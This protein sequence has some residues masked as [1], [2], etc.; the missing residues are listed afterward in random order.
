MACVVSVGNQDPTSAGS[1][2][3][4]GSW[5]DIRRLGGEVTQWRHSPGHLVMP[6][7]GL[8]LREAARGARFDF[9]IKGVRLYWP[10]SPPLIYRG[11]VAE[12]SEDWTACGLWD[13]V[14]GRVP[15]RC[16]AAHH[17]GPSG[18][19]TGSDALHLDRVDQT[20]IKFGSVCIRMVRRS[21]SSRGHRKFRIPKY[22]IR[23]PIRSAALIGD[24]IHQRH[25]PH[26]DLAVSSSQIQN[27]S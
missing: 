7:R 14:V 24:G 4:A 8:E 11:G 1:R 22:E 5:T 17:R 16:P 19:R 13:P 18:R 15:S 23:Y 26:P 27:P 20:P 21:R 3:P 10:M 6:N 2:V 9:F 25:H 12:I